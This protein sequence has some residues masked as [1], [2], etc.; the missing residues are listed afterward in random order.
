[1]ISYVEIIKKYFAAIRQGTEEPTSEISDLPPQRP[2][3]LR[4]IET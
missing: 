1:M 2:N 3:Y 4:Y